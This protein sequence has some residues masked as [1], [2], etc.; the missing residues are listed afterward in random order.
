[1]PWSGKTGW[2]RI[3]AIIL[4][5]AVSLLV[6]VVSVWA[7]TE[8]S[9]NIITDR[10]EKL[11]EDLRSRVA[12]SPAFLVERLFEMQENSF[13][14]FVPGM[15]NPVCFS[16]GLFSFDPKTFPDSFLKGLVYDVENGSP[17]YH[18]R[19]RE[20]RKTRQIE[21]LDAN[22]R[23][24]YIF[25]PSADYDPL[26][27]ARREFPDTFLATYDPSKRAF[28]EEW[29]DPS[30][31][32]MDIALIPESYVETYAE[33]EVSSLL[34]ALMLEEVN[35]LATPK[36]I[37]SSGTTMMKAA[38]SDTNVVIAQM[39]KVSTGTLLRVDYPD[40][41]TNRLEVMICTNLIAR[42][43]WLAETNLVTVGTNSLMWVD[44]G[45]TNGDGDVNRFYQIGN[46]ADYDGDGVEDGR[47]VIMYRTDPNALDSDG[48]GLVD[49][50]SGFVTT[51]SYPGGITTNGSIYVLGEMSL[52]TDPT[53]FD[54]DGDGC[55]DGWEVAHGHNPLDPNDPPN[56]SGT[57]FYTGRQTGMVWVIATTDSNSWNT[58]QCFTSSVSASPCPL[59]YLISDLEQTNYLDK[60]LDGQQRERGHQ[61]ARSPWQSDRYRHY[62]HQPHDRAGHHHGRS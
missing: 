15:P 45:A 10:Q 19:L 9:R 6:A 22:G 11:I 44:T 13:R 20:V 14:L 62:H 32:E 42:H 4:T 61:C 43:W 55:G 47:E 51:N 33:G 52:G 59:P 25:N 50:Y 2:V 5:A 41:F 34:D 53:K 7:I 24:F 17:V 28:M 40:T 36:K 39:T 27:L 57:I 60:S 21:V 37:V 8:I 35:T 38:G 30:H 16:A 48:D 12:E 23:V 3:R 1:M 54:T 31:V 56:V 58:A 49:G 46:S 26:W 29:T 18:L